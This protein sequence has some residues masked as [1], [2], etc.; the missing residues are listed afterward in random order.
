MNYNIGKIKEM[1][2]AAFSTSEIIS[3]AFDHYYDVY[4]DLS[5]GL[6]K[7]QVIEK[8]IDCAIK[9]N[10]LDTILWYTKQNRRYQY[11]LFISFILTS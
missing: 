5:F 11:D 8:I 1:L 9:E 2:Q 3:M 10:S 4:N 7:R 6:P